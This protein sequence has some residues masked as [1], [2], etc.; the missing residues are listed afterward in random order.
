MLP[1]CFLFFFPFLFFAACVLDSP[2]LFVG[3][4]LDM[5][6]SYQNWLPCRNVGMEIG[7]KES[8]HVVSHTF[9]KCSR[10]LFR[11]NFFTFFFFFLNLL[12]SYCSPTNN[13]KQCWVLVTE[14]PR[15]LGCQEQWESPR[16]SIRARLSSQERRCPQALTTTIDNYFP[17]PCALT[18][19]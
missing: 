4:V 16:V 1:W 17:T 18:P 7:H 13:I 2:F 6:A 10:L 12:L 14:A 19:A 5:R 15:G 8:F 3:F 11:S 9:H